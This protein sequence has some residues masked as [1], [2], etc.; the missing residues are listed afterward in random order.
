MVSKSLEVKKTQIKTLYQFDTHSLNP[1]IYFIYLY[2]F[3]LSIFFIYLFFS[4]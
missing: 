3:N 2:Y 4:L 1:P